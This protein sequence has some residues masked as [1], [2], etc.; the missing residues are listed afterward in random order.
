MAQPFLATNH[1]LT[2][3]FNLSSSDILVDQIPMLN[4]LRRAMEELQ[5]MTPESSGIASATSSI[6]LEQLPEIWDHLVKVNAGKWEKIA[7]YQMKTAF[8]TDEAT[9]RLQAKR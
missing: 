2:I 8:V 9:M 6:V 1:S 4:E 7:D 3:F 5:L